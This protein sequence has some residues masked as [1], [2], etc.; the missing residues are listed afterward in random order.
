MSSNVSEHRQPPV[1]MKDWQPPSERAPSY[2]RPQEPTLI[3][4]VG[5]VGIVAAVIGT[6]AIGFILAGRPSRFV[7]V[8]WGSLLLETGLLAMLLHAASDRDT[9]IRRTYTV[10]GFL[11]LAAG[12][13]LSLLA[14]HTGSYLVWGFP[15][16]IGALL[17]LTVSNRHEDNADWRNSTTLT[18]GAAGAALALTGFIGGNI[19]QF[20]TPV[21]L[22]LGVLG[23]A[24]LCCFVVSRGVSDNL[25]YWG[26][27]AM[28]AVGVIAF[29]VALGRSV[30]PS[31]LHS[32]HWTQAMPAHYFLPNGFLLIALGLVYA[33]ASAM[34]CSDNRLLVMTR[35]ELASFFYSPV[36]YIAL[37][38]WTVVGGL[39]FMPLVERLVNVD[40]RNPVVE[41]VVGYYFLSWLVVIGIIFVVPM[42]T[43]R[44]LSEE[45]RSGTLEVML[46]APIDEVSLVL[47]KFLAAS[48]FFVLLSLPWGIYL[49]S[50]RIGAGQPFDYMPL[51]SFTV[52]NLA[53]GAGLMAMGLFFSS[54][55]QHQVISFA[56]TFVMMLA[57]TAA[58]LFLDRGPEAASTSH[59]SVTQTILRH[60]SYIQL[61]ISSLTGQLQFKYVVFHLTMAVLWL[62]ATVKVLDIRKWA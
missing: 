55:T 38:V 35:R 33:A 12:I 26:G 40:P 20:L 54:V 62:F 58:F 34:L 2:T 37:L 1:E 59:Q 61:W 39:E 21:G 44:L 45:K 11:L 50:L 46:T 24:Y 7:G 4:V 56:L 5:M 32:W 28:G 23:L 18:L 57:L 22:L 17:F 8:F 27:V 30:I 16:L 42:L 13:V 36:A 47:S 48:I 53:I 29:L 31:L 14:I 43:M 15:C 49:L 19:G 41:P 9:Q 3:R 52:V 25:G 60:I 10:F 51:L 6:M